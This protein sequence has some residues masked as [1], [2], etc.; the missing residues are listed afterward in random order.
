M[1][2][3]RTSLCDLLNIEVPILQAG[4]GLV[5]YADLAAAAANAGAF[6]CLGGIDIPVYELEHEIKKF[7]SLSD[8]PLGVDLGF[9]EHAPAGLADV[10]LPDPLPEPVQTL[11][12]ELAE[13][14]V[15]VRDDEPDQ[16]ISREDN[17][18]KLQIAL[19]L[20]VETI[21]CG[22]GTPVEVVELAKSRGAR[23][24]SIVGTS[25]A[26]R[27]VIGNGTDAVI[28]QGTEGGGHSGF[29][30][31][32]VLLAEVLDFATVPVIAAGGI[33][34]GAQ[35]AG[36]LTAGAEGVWI[37]TRF[38]VTKEGGSEDAF[39][40]ALV[41]AGPSSTVHTP[42]F[43]GLHVRQLRNRFITAWEG[44]ESEYAGYPVQRR[45]MIPIR[46]AAARAE[47]AD[48]MNLACGQG[49]SLIDDIPGA[50]ELVGRLVAETV[51]AL[52]ASTTRIS[53]SA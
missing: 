25:R 4:M 49:V 14:G 35:I 31:T 12:R 11:R 45:L 21:V 6:G 22:L 36:Y 48:Y 38:L 3:L 10:V 29:V 43:D 16:A 28:V 47:Q 24:M 52:Q 7:R 32:S 19:D 33:T 51:A 53:Y 30:G 27:K 39:K 15:E 37:G 26:A 20:G 41:E 8:K 1:T 2:T 9:P 13:L 46:D 44:K 50:G 34:T 18:E 17:M 40:N 42:I 23:V 5:S